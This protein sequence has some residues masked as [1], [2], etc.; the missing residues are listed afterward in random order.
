MSQT[1]GPAPGDYGVVHG[2]G[3]YSWAIEV[4][5]KSPTS[6]AF[7]VVEGNK[8]VEAQ[9]SGAIVSPLS[10]YAHH[11]VAYNDEEYKSPAEREGIVA[12]AM[13]LVGTPYNWWDI[14]ALTM[15]SFGLASPWM[16]KRAQEEKSLVC[17]ALVSRSYYLGAGIDLA[18]GRPDATVTP[19]DLANRILFRSWEVATS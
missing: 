7:V 12:H 16:W 15:D 1:K 10:K 2:S 5:T 18:N 9:P 4:G 19:G 3:F 17:S 6:H 13:K 11:E 8:I 14:F